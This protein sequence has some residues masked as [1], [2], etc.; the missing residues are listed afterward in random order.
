MAEVVYID[1]RLEVPTKPK[2]KRK[3]F[4]DPDNLPSLAELREIYVQRFGTRPPD[5]LFDEDE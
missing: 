2:R 3:T 4:L 1:S 5:F